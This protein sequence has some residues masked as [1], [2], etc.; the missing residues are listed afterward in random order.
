MQ[1]DITPCFISETIRP[2]FMTHFP[3]SWHSIHA[4]LP[5]LGSPVSGTFSQ[6]IL[7]AQHALPSLFNSFYLFSF[8]S[9]C[10]F[11][12]SHLPPLPETPPLLLLLFAGNV[13]LFS[14]IN[15]RNIVC[16]YCYLHDYLFII[17]MPPLLNWNFHEGKDYVVL[18][19]FSLLYS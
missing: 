3:C 2:H 19:L 17:H 6:V 14:I 7:S 1:R 10:H 18:L 12:N 8:V 4:H 9:K 15:L 5:S 16:L 11:L 13:L